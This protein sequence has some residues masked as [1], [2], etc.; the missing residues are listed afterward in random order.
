MTTG[1]ENPEDAELEGGEQGR[2]TP[3]TNDEP[4]FGFSERSVRAHNAVSTRSNDCNEDA[5]GS[6]ASKKL[7]RL[8]KRFAPQ[9]GLSKRE[10]PMGT[11]RIPITTVPDVDYLLSDDD[12]FDHKSDKP[13]LRNYS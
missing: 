3:L 4:K 8:Y 9:Q 5:E 7:E 12:G 11:K 2:V 1:L 10:L 6:L 13:F